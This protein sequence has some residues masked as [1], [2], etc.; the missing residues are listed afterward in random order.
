M[1][2]WVLMDLVPH[3]A[4]GG[5]GW[6]TGSIHA[7]DGRHAASLAQEALFRRRRG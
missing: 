4:A 1:D 6:Y 7:A 5:R 2:D 3:S